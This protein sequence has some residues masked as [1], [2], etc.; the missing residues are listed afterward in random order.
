M[1]LLVALV[2]F[3]SCLLGLT[4]VIYPLRKIG[5]TTRVRGAILFLFGVVVMGV[6][7][8][9]LPPPASQPATVYAPGLQEPTPTQP[10][11][12]REWTRVASWSGSGI[13]D[14]ETFTTTQ[15]EWR[16]NW[17][18]QKEPFQGAGILQIYVHNEDGALVNLA[19]NAQGVRA[20]V[21]YVRAP[22]GRYYLKLNSANVEYSIDVE[23]Q[24]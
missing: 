3:V 20:D 18:T 11:R 24:R 21:S 1:G 19:A 22:P 10:S 4:S 13:K 8:A 17:R 23:E 16:I 9:M 7:G 6:G 15:R 5:I 2:G 12:P 14:T